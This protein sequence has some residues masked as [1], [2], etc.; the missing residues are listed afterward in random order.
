MVLGGLA[1]RKAVPRN[2]ASLRDFE[3]P[4]HAPWS[5]AGA[6]T[7]TVVYTRPPCV[8][9]SREREKRPAAGREKLDHAPKSACHTC[10]SCGSVVNSRFVFTHPTDDYKKNTIAKDVRRWCPSAETNHR[11]EK[12][13]V[14]SSWSP[15]TP[16]SKCEQIRFGDFVRQLD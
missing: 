11:S 8:P 10:T 1:S 5:P 9:R 6:R 14:S 3:R 15:R 13:R 2:K 4:G 16:P 7:C 12:L